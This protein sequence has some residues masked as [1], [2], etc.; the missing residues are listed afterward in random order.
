MGACGSQHSRD[1]QIQLKSTK[2]TAGVD[3]NDVEFQESTD[4]MAEVQHKITK[5]YTQKDFKLLKTVGKGSFGRVFMVSRNSDDKIF[6]MKVLNKQK[7]IERNQY[8]H[9]L[10][11]R[12]I[13]EDIDHP[14]LV[15]LRCSFQSPTKLF[16]VFDF[17]NGGELYSY[18][19]RG[20]FTEDRARFYSGE[21]ILAIEHLH[22][23]NIVY[24]DLKPE[25]L[26]LDREGH[27]KLCDFGL[28][29]E[30]VTGDTVKTIC[31]TP[32]Y[33]APEVLQHKTYGKSVDWWSL[34]NVMFEMIAGLPPF[35]DNNR[36]IMFRKILQA[37]L[38]KP[39]VMSEDAFNLITGMLNR[40]PPHRL[41]YKGANDIKSAAW[42]RQERWGKDWVRLLDPSLL[43]SSV[44]RCF[45]LNNDPVTLFSNF[46]VAC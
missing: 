1:E 24:R 18:V 13:L 8:E 11:E 17:F 22:E 2:E 23:H 15:G 6:A 34:G 42:F 10:S 28:C 9:T 5:R 46:L 36:Q 38:F 4:D 32:E 39:R 19:S 33:L 3:S 40:N 16:M 25:N 29:K 21:I 37:P 43:V 20:R 45:Q 31:G 35:F 44:S 30:D 12:K 41:G 26:L 27:I 7:L 14:F